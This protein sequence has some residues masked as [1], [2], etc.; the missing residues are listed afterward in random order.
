MPA[1]SS[2]LQTYVSYGLQGLLVPECANLD[3]TWPAGGAKCRLE[4]P[5]DNPACA[6]KLTRHCIVAWRLSFYWECLSGRLH[7]RA[8]WF[9]QSFNGGKELGRDWDIGQFYA[10]SRK[11][12]A[13]MRPRKD[14]SFC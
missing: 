10:C 12:V 5:P 11:M 7:L 9:C 3:P 6:N 8:T 4:Q 1:G 14:V 2:P 13:E